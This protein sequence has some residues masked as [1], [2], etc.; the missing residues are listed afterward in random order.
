MK[1][2]RGLWRIPNVDI[3]TGAYRPLG[4]P[5]EKTA[6]DTKGNEKSLWVPDV[7]EKAKTFIRIFNM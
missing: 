3:I 1:S 4:I 7:E 2:E 5:S 6:W